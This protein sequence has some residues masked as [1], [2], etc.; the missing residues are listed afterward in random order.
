[1]LSSEQSQEEVLLSHL[2]TVTSGIIKDLQINNAYASWKNTPIGLRFIKED[3]AKFYQGI[4]IWLQITQSQLIGTSDNELIEKILPRFPWI[5][6]LL[7]IK[8]IV[9][10]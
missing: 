1:M 10:I 7:E 3:T 9:N 6:S 2:E 5:N 4:G 8:K